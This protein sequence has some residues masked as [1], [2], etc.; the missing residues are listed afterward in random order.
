MSKGKYLGEFE[1]LVLVALLRL[2]DEAYGV[3]VR[4]EIEKQSSRAVSIGAVYA[5]LGRLETKR[6]I[7]SRIG[8]PTAARGGRAKRFFRIT[9]GGSRALNLSISTLNRMVDGLSVEWS[10]L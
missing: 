6:Y 7:S 5:T 9:K 1:T 10:A 2:G 4:Q 3:R 8:E